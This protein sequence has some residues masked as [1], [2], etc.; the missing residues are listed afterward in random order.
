MALLLVV[1]AWD[2]S[3]AAT[4]FEQDSECPT[5][6]RLIRLADAFESRGLF[7]EARDA[8]RDAFGKRC[9]RLGETV[10]Y[11]VAQ[12][13][14]AIKIAEVE[15]A[16]ENL[17]IARELIDAR[18]FDD[19]K[20]HLNK[21]DALEVRDE[22]AHLATVLYQ[23]KEHLGG[24]LLSGLVDAVTG[25]MLL[26]ARAVPVVFLGALVAAARKLSSRMRQSASE[27]CESPS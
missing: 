6:Q 20:Q 24:R 3:V 18:R 19:A 15:Q 1:T 16:R 26:A 14:Q 2:W 25:L 9:Q 5:V 21:A 13:T 22:R 23:A 4:A 27:I 17:R 11:H 12:L 8:Y 10:V 7:R